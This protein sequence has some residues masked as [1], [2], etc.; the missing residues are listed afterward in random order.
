MSFDHNA[1]P[2]SEGF[3]L[4]P[5]GD[6]ELQIV[7]VKEKQTFKD[8]YPMVN[9]EC[10]V[11]NHAELNGKKIFHNVT[12]LPADKPGAGISTHFL[13]S[14]NQPWEG[15]VRVEPINWVGEK[16]KA[17]V[18]TRE[19]EVKKDGPNKGK[20]QKANDI[21]EIEPMDIPF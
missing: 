8:K 15:A 18:G 9:V 14:I 4:L 5:D 7:N 16:F 3:S 21:Q 20:I 10:E 1:A 6:Y 12:F 17:K 11:I 19:Y 2:P 13:K